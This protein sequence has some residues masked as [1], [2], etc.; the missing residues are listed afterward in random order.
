[1]RADPSQVKFYFDKNIWSDILSMTD[2]ELRGF[3][4]L[5]EPLKKQVK[6]GIWHSPIGVLELVKQM[7]L[8]KHYDECR[9]EIT[10]ASEITDKNLLDHP[11]DHIRRIA[12]NQMGKAFHQPDTAFLNLCREIAVL[13]YSQMKQKIAR[14][15]KAA[16]WE[17]NWAQDLTR[18]ATDMRRDFGLEPRDK[19]RRVQTDEFRSVRGVLWRRMKNWRFFCRHFRLPSELE[20]LS[21]EDAIR[22]FPSFLYWVDY[23]ITYENKVIYESK[24]PRPSDYLHWEQLVYLNI[25][26]YL[27][28]NDRGLR[29]VLEESI[30]PELG[31]VTLG[32]DQFV[33]CLRGKLPPRRAP[34]SADRVWMDTRI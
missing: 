29:K 4:E 24:K 5:I 16:R 12:Y 33:A 6:I 10:L 25:M 7:S 1:M 27:V 30:N 13:P 18:V 9:R 28:T 20:D 14:L 21:F 17:K 32:F 11:W 34:D 3:R 19:A 22:L 8:E 15:R 2:S 23:R 31:Q 26:D